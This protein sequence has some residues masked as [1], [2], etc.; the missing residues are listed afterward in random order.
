MRKKGG[1][2]EGEGDDGEV[3]A[4]TPPFFSFSCDGRVP[5][6]PL[7]PILAS[8]R[9]GEEIVPS[10]SENGRTERESYREEEGKGAKAVKVSPPPRSK[11][12]TEAAAAVA[13]CLNLG[14]AVCSN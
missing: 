6:P 3:A 8:V 7:P 9:R 12:R 14:V 5:P 11:H 1:S 2:G 13:W 10:L 4:L